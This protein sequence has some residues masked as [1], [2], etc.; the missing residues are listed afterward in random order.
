M[1]SNQPVVDKQAP[2]V[3]T[4]KAIEYFAVIHASTSYMDYTPKNGQSIGQTQSIKLTEE[5]LMRLE[6]KPFR[7][8][9]A[10]A[11]DA[12]ALRPIKD[13]AA[14]L[15]GAVKYHKDLKAALEAIVNSLENQPK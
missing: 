13:M 3:Y 4:V 15:N 7:W 12:E 2:G 8:V 6:V 10:V 1:E 11:E 14:G 9:K 5:G